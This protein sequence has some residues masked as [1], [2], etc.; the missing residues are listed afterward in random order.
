[1]LSS[2][3]AILVINSCIFIVLGSRHCQ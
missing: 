3:L 2:Y 1:M